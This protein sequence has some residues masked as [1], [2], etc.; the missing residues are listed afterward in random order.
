MLEKAKELR[1]KVVGTS[2]V[3]FN[4]MAEALSGLSSFREMVLDWAQ[5]GGN[6]QFLVSDRDD[7]YNAVMQ[8]QYLGNFFKTV[9]YFLISFSR[10]WQ[11]QT[12]NF[13][14][15]DQ[16]DDWTDI[17]LPLYAARG[18]FI[19]TADKKL[20]NAVAMIDP[21]GMLRAGPSVPE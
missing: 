16:R 10:A 3:K 7:L 21:S 9:L 18:D 13:D 8:N 15:S 12:H 11:D 4:D 19:L 1:K 2:T 17:T 20:R 5:D 6:R 14:P